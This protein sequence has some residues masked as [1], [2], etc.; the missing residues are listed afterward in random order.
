M[1]HLSFYLPGSLVE[2]RVSNARGE[3]TM[4]VPLDLNFAPPLW[5]LPPAFKPLPWTNLHPG[6]LKEMAKELC[7]TFVLILNNSWNTGKFQRN[8]K[9]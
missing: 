1:N 3:P 5:E 7:E 2:L 4:P 6:E 9:K 8:E